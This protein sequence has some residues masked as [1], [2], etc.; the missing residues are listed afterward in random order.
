MCRV[1]NSEHRGGGN[2]YQTVRSGH[3]KIKSREEKKIRK[4]PG[5]AGVERAEAPG[6]G[7]IIASQPL[8][9]N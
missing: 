2:S 5:V 3:R 6:P 8:T 4:L 7:G 9:A 1:R